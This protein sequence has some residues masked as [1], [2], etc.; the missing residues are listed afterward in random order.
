MNGKTEKYL[1]AMKL[2]S[3]SVGEIP[4][5]GLLRAFVDDKIADSK[6]YSLLLYDRELSQESLEHYELEYIGAYGDIEWLT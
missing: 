1:Y 4:I 6:I 3:F 5:K 2:K